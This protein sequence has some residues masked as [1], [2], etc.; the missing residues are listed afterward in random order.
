MVRRAVL[1]ILLGA[2]LFVSPS[3]LAKGADRDEKPAKAEEPKGEEKPKAEQP[4]EDKAE[5]EGVRREDRGDE[6]D[7]DE[8]DG[9]RY[10][11]GR[12]YDGRYGHGYYYE[13]PSDPSHFH[14]RMTAD[15]EVP[16]PGPAGGKGLARLD[17]DPYEHRVCYEL[18]YEGIG[19]PTGA[20]IHRGERGTNGPVVV[21]FN[22]AR[23]GDRACVAGNPRVL[24]DMQ[25]RPQ[26]Y[27]V[28]LHTA[29]FPDGA[30]RG[31]VD[32]PTG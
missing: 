20:H 10:R 16:K 4:R 5:D 7:G 18:S 15:Q 22:I 29:D 30:I 12:Y 23:N 31:Q 26:Q 17:V 32:Y 2:L 9:D 8:G 1:A 28:N 14:A 21:D 3:A 13:E 19:K 27:Y 25:A 24:R 6:G 11:D